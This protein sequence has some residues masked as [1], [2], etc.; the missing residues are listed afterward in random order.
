M[1]INPEGKYEDSYQKKERLKK[2]LITA[3]DETSNFLSVL[4][5]DFGNVEGFSEK[6]ETLDIKADKLTK[7]EHSLRKELK[8]MELDHG[9]LSEGDE[10]AKKLEEEIDAQR[11]EIMDIWDQI[12]SLR[13]QQI[14]MMEE[15]STERGDVEESEAI[16]R[17]KFKKLE[18]IKK[19]LDELEGK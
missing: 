14:K 2:E 1:P 13:Q 19:Q 11:E 17:M 5:K 3:F 8:R 18:E 15:E 4:K 16:V 9:K 7:Q 10:S 12:D 6:F